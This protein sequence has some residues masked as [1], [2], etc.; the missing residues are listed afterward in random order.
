MTGSGRQTRTLG[1]RLVGQAGVL[2]QQ[3]QQAQIS[4]IQ[5]GG[6]AVWHGGIY[7]IY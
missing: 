2:L 5:M 7:Q 4:V 3:A 1:Q 6:G